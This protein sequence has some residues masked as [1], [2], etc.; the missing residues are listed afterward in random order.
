MQAFIRRVPDV[1]YQS[2][3]CTV[4]SFTSQ[5]VTR[6]WRC[7]TKVCRINEV[8]LRRARLVLGRV[9]VSRFNSRRC[10]ESGR[11]FHARD[12]ATVNVVD[13]CVSA[14]NVSQ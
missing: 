6:A 3:R 7:G 13:Q 8:T 9:T 2:T 5:L 14:C 4:N 12:A 10:S 1:G 11:L